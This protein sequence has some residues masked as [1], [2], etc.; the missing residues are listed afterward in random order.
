MVA[1]MGV[2]ERLFGSRGKAVTEEQVREALFEAVAAGD[3]EALAGLC[4]AHEAV[5]LA[6]FGEWTRVP[7]S[8]RTPD[9]LPRYGAGLIAV[10]RHFAE[11]RGRPELMQ[12]MMGPP[13][14]NPLVMWKRALGEVDS[15]MA[16]LRYEEA[17]E[18]LRETLDRT[19]GLQGTGAEAYRPITLGRLGDCLMQAGDIDGARTATERALAGC[20]AAGDGEGV[21]AYLGNLYEIERYRGDGSAAAGWLERLAETRERLGQPGLAARHRRRAS[22]VRAGE[23]LCRVVAEID[24]E[25]VELADLSPVKGSVR[26]LFERNRITLRRCTQ[27][28]EQ[29][30]AAAERGELEA[31][32]VCFER[33]AAADAFDPW[34]RY[35]A[36]MAQLELRRYD[37]AVASYRASERLAPG[38]YQTRSTGW[39]AEQLAAG[40]LDHDTFLCVR[41]LF[42]GGSSP[43]ACVALA[44]AALQRKEL[45][46]LRLALGHALDEQGRRDEAEDAYR[47]GLAIAEEPDVRTRLLVA[48][49]NRISDPQAKARCL[50]DAVNLA[51]NLVA[52]ATAAV[53]LVSQPAN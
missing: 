6:R 16:E 37:D 20:A 18:R 50:R 14:S 21:V 45:G 17:A 41:Q 33:A 11:K 1:A 5:V 39:L 4:A 31:A 3:D 15:M 29:G 13:E 40:A 23:P 32:L 48:L 24:G 42:D 8:H 25:T 30:V 2:L 36:G 27:G 19:E 51:G 44:T 52:A 9:K 38:W 49:A 46:A 22:I 34:P 43:V 28:V 26:F 10:A 53:M 7:E 12:R 47:R 35:H